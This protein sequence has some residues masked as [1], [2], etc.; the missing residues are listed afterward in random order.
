MTMRTSPARA[1]MQYQNSDYQKVFPNVFQNA[2]RVTEIPVGRHALSP[3]ATPARKGPRRVLVY[4]PRPRTYLASAD[5]HP[6]RRC[7]TNIIPQGLWDPRRRGGPHH[8]R[9]VRGRRMRAR[10]ET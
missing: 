10:R 5:V 2:F 6:K 1:R 4:S 8:L 7:A 9:G 3:A